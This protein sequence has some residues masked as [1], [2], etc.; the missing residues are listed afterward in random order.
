M[1]KVIGNLKVLIGQAAVDY[2]S[3][4]AEDFRSN[5]PGPQ[6]IQGNVGP[7]G[8]GVHHMKGTSTTDSEGD[9]ATAGET[10]TY[11]FYADANETVPLAWFS[12]KNGVDPYKN[13]ADK[14]Y[15]GSENEFY[16]SLANIQEYADISEAA[17]II[18]TA[19]KNATAAD[20]LVVENDKGI[21]Q[22]A[23]A[24]AVEAKDIAVDSADVV[25]SI[26]LGRKPV[27]PT[28]DNQG[29]PLEIGVMYYN[30]AQGMLKIW[31]GDHWATGAFA[32]E[33]AVIS[34]NGR[35]GAV[36]LTSGDIQVALGVDVVAEVNA[37]A[38]KNDAVLTGTPVAPTAAVGTSTTQIATTGFVVN[39]IN[40]VEE[41]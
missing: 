20:R 37:R 7:Q 23:S 36:T 16:L 2:I 27:D 6:G 17:V 41:W 1:A 12:I 5:T 28:T 39:E 34:F 19:N 10:D 26:F 29:R 4:N 18:T 32:A 3:L 14:G 9:F 15:V 24:T 40:K 35:D 30:S 38:L 33:G 13:A 31:T 22:V 21:A 11:T 8:V 25:Q